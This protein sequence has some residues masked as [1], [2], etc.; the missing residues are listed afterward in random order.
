MHARLAAWSVSPW[1]AGKPLP[2]TVM[3]AA[4]ASLSLP[5]VAKSDAVISQVHGGGNAGAVWRNDFIGLVNR[6]ASPASL[7]GWSV[8]Y[9]SAS[10]SN[11]SVT[12]LPA[13]DLQ[14]GQYLLVRQARGAGARGSLAMS[15]G[16]ARCWQ[17]MARRQQRRYRRRQ[18]DA[19]QRCPNAAY[20]WML[21]TGGLAL[22]GLAL[23]RRQTV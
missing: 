7:A 5:G 1:F 18:R 13:I 10:G 11:W 17:V 8:Q 14:A 21:L 15:G 3:A 23:R 22:I 4:L 16:Q 19:A 12:A 6:G 9:A 20:D 2:L